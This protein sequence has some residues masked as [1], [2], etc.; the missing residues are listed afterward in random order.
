MILWWVAVSVVIIALC[1]AVAFLG[2]KYIPEDAIQYEE[3]RQKID[4]SEFYNDESFPIKVSFHGKD[5]F[6]LLNATT[7]TVKN[8]TILTVKTKVNDYSFT[9][10]KSAWNKLINEKGSGYKGE[11]F[12]FEAGGDK[13]LFTAESTSSN[14][15]MTCYIN[16]EDVKEADK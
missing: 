10:P 11:G 14:P 12:N 16:I 6:S 4:L 15:Q 9:L 2:L 8:N 5:E 7:A 1:W 13:I 3:S